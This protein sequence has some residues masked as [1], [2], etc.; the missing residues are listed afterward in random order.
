[1]PI[2]GLKDNTYVLALSVLGPQFI[3]TMIYLSFKN[4]VSYAWRNNFENW[5]ML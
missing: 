5:N 2:L 4:I 1:M 3:Y